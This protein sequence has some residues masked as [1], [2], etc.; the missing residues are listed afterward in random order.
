MNKIL[1]AL[2]VIALVIATVLFVGQK[3]NDVSELLLTKNDIYQL[4]LE[5]ALSFDGK[6]CLMEKQE[7]ISSS[8]MQYVICNYTMKDLDD[9][10]VVV[11][12]KKFTNKEDLYNNYE[13]ESQ[14]LF[15][16]QGLISENELGDK[17]RFRVNNEN[18]FG[19]QY[20]EPNIYYY[21]LWVCKDS[22]LIHVTSKGSQKAGDSVIR[23]GKTILSK[24]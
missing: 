8:K 7:S 17:S 15:S 14:H 12:I 6:A 18:D 19:A 16:A 3:S 10:W 24:I 1:L 22:Y 23:I 2:I 21:H 5:E 20:N 13:Y 9:T 11:E 4:N